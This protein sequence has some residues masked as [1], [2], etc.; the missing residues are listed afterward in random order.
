MSDFEKLQGIVRDLSKRVRKFEANDW[1]T[2]YCS[3][4]LNGWWANN[5]YGNAKLT[6]EGIGPFEALADIEAKIRR[7]EDRD[8]SLARTLGIEVAA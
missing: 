7:L 3:D 2:L 4:F 6:G 1:V 5:H 8:D